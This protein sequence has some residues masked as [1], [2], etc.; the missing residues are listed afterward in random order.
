MRL[1]ATIEGVN[2]HNWVCT[3]TFIH[4]SLVRSRSYWWERL[5][6]ARANDCWSAV[7]LAQSFGETS[8]MSEV[9]ARCSWLPGWLP[10]RF[11][12]MNIHALSHIGNKCFDS[13]LGALRIKIESTWNITIL[14]MWKMVML[15]DLVRLETIDLML[16]QSLF[17]RYSSWFCG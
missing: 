9:T 13:V 6:G 5:S 3:H 7:D 15:P 4:E 10:V 1:D 2:N 11:S 17:W 12:L 14:S 8:Q 16:T